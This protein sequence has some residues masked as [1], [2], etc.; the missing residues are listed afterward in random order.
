MAVQSLHNESHK[1]AVPPT[2][3][4]HLTPKQSSQITKSVGNQCTLNCKLNGLF[5]EALWDTGAQV[6]II[7]EQFHRNRFPGIKLL[8]SISQL[9]DC[10]LDLTVA[11]G[12]SIP[13]TGFVR[14]TFTLKNRRDPILVPFLVTTD[15]ISMPLVGYN[16][17]ELCIK[18][19]LTSPELACVFS[20]LSH[21]N[22][23]TLYDIIEANND[24]DLC[25]VGTNKKN[26]VIKRGQCSEISCR[27]NHGPIA[28]AIPVIFEPE[29]NQELP[30]GLVVSES[31][32]S[33]K[34]R[35]TSGSKFVVENTTKHD[36][37]LPKR[38]VL[39]WIQLVQSV[40]PIDVKLKEKSAS[41]EPT[42]NANV[43]SEVDFGK[44]IP[45]HV[46]QINLDGLMET[47]KQSALNLLCEKQN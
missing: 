20:S 8:R 42:I 10:E 37:V 21:N 5:V 31:L 4:T 29:E 38:M 26:A 22:V 19:G 18:S 6:S 23:N 28:S 33:L 34:P 9:I 45:S 16:A 35:K 44:N 3:L 17:I 2:F 43:S 30:H 13:Y 39:G 27:I 25:T 47:Q 36:I 24:A 7:S 40:T 14:F 46:K 11:N 1:N 12:T 41:P 15:D 32:F